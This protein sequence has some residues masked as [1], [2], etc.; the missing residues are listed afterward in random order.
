MKTHQ[1]H[2]AMRLVTMVTNTVVVHI[3]A[4]DMKLT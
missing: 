2:L 4:V 3:L 1:S